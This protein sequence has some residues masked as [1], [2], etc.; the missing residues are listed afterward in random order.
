MKKYINICCVILGIVLIPN[1]NL[2]EAKEIDYASTLFIELKKQDLYTI[3]QK[4]IY[5]S[6]MNGCIEVSSS[7]ERYTNCILRKNLQLK[8]EIDYLES[9][10]L[11]LIKAI[12]TNEKK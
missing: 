8:K 3:E 7:Y 1:I 5:L 2:V 4:I 11:E 12:Q 9:K 6:D 10:N